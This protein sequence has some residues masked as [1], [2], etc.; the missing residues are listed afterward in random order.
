MSD[1]AVQCGSIGIG[2]VEWAGG[3]IF[4][5]SVWLSYLTGNGVRNA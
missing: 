4:F 5:H 2:Y 3:L 1:S